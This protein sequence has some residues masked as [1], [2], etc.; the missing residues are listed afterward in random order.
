MRLKITGLRRVVKRE[1]GIE[2]GCEQLTSYG[3]LELVRR[4]FQSIGLN[5][6]IRHGFREHNLGGDYGC[7]H[8]VVL[9]VGLLVVGARRVIVTMTAT[10]SSGEPKLV[11]ECTYPLTAPAAADVVITDLGVFRFRPEGLVLTELLGDAT[12]HAV[13]AVTAAPYA[14]DLDGVGL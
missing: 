14:V 10:S 8:L 11:G 2:F 6:R 7:V 12:L 13:A 4:Y 9:V 5:R 3:G 1:L